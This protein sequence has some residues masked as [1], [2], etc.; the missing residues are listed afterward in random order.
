MAAKERPWTR[1]VK[2]E[3]K[4]STRQQQGSPK[5]T[6]SCSSEIP[7]LTY[8]SKWCHFNTTP[9]SHSLD[10]TIRWQQSSPATTACLQVKEGKTITH[11][12]AVENGQTSGTH[13]NNFAAL[14]PCDIML[15]SSAHSLRLQGVCSYNISIWGKRGVARRSLLKL[16][17]GSSKGTKELIY[18]QTHSRYT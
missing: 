6:A 3:I 17:K 16:S 7:L 18:I 4:P 13:D 11:V 1:E 2:R 14:L 10:R 9:Q 15:S 12:V 5:T 8:R